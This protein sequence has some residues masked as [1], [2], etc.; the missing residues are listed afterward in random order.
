MEGMISYTQ[1][2][3]ERTGGDAVE[4]RNE[5]A[6]DGA[7]TIKID[8]SVASF[9][10]VEGPLDTPNIAAEGFFALKKL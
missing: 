6:T 5:L 3:M 10:R 4:I 9:E 8:V 1:A 7:E 2:A